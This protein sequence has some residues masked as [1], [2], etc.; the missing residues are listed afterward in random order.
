M[1][2]NTVI[3]VGVG[4]IV[5]GGLFFVLKPD[6]NTP[7]NAEKKSANDATTQKAPSPTPESRIKTFTLEVKD[8]KI[9]KG[10]N[11]IIVREGDE[12]TINITADEDEEFHLH[13]YDKSVDLERDRE[14]SLVFTAILTGRFPAELEHSKTEITAIEVQPK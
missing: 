6:R 11:P 12:V 3:L 5:L 9:V 13:G 1:K 8:K 14:S 10:E 2:K 4:L 7:Q